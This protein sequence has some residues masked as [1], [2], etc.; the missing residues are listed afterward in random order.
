VPRI[1]TVKPEIHQDEAVGELSDSAFRLFIGLI[2][3]ADDLGRL[4]GDPRLLGAQVWPY[5]PKT[6]EEVKGWLSE[7]SAA[8]LIQQ[9]THTEKPFIALPSWSNHQRID[10]ASKSRIP[11]PNSDD[12]EVSPRD[13]ASRGDSRLDQGRE[14]KGS[15]KGEE[16]A[17]SA[18]STPPT[19]FAVFESLERVS[20]ARSISSPKVSATADACEEFADR[21]LPAEARKFAHY[22]IEGPG[23]K[24]PL[25]DVAWAWRNWLEKVHVK[26]SGKSARS[27]VAD[28][29][30]RLEAEHAAAVA[31]EAGAAA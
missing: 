7:L 16:A 4:K 13:S 22:W 9:Y 15:R 30:K 11:E 12:G 6:V 10:N 2:T 26:P 28:D 23:E 25:S 5:A 20:F 19:H 29:L 1:R 27:T 21:D 24:R 18:A 8:G 3:Q 17:A 31:E 14:G